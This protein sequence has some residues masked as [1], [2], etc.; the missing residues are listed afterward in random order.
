VSNETQIASSP[1]TATRRS[2]RG[3]WLAGRAQVLAN[4]ARWNDLWRRDGAA[5][6]LARAELLAHWH[7]ALGGGSRL[8]VLVIEDGEHWVAA[9]P[10]VE[11]RA[12]WRPPVN[13]LPGDCWSPAGDLLLDRGCRP[14]AAR[15]VATELAG[16]N[17][18]IYR[19]AHLRLERPSWRSLLNALPH[20]NLQYRVE[21]QPPVAVIPF[22]DNWAAFQA[23][24]SKNRRKKFRRQRKRLEAHGSVRLELTEG[25]SAEQAN[26]LLNL[27]FEI[28]DRSWKGAAGSSILRT[29][30]MA[31]F[32]RQQARLLRQAG[33]LRLAV[34]YCGSTAVAYE[35]GWVHN[36]TYTSFKVGYDAQFAD[37]GPGN[38]LLYLLL[39][40]LHEEGGV[41]AIDCMTPATEA[42]AAFRPLAEPAGHLLIGRKG[43][44]GR[45]LWAA[46]HVARPAVRAARR[47]L[48]RESGP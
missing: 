4:T 26:R 45:A 6:P 42:L 24:L 22:A 37:Y 23:R 25:Q 29:P 3:R 7:A 1:A 21:P 48:R 34:L 10:L 20:C 36:A 19:V 16:G 15:A 11:Q 38:L 30:G 5:S 12:L 35:Y 46:M 32:Y 41:R 44:A 31:D 18:G 8:R 9:L 17:G 13:A 28:E 47:F 43:I 40:G 27:G 2:F 33:E 39:E 14:Q